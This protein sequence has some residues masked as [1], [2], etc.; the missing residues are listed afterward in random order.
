M[1]IFL[2]ALILALLAGA[3]FV[4]STDVGDD[5]GTCVTD[6]GYCGYHDTKDAYNTC[7]ICCDADPPEYRNC[8][9]S[10]LYSC[11][12]SLAALSGH[13]CTRSCQAPVHDCSYHG[14]GNCCPMNNGLFKDC[15]RNGYCKDRTQRNYCKSLNGYCCPTPG[16]IYLEC[17]KTQCSWHPDST[18]RRCATR[19][20]NNRGEVLACSCAK[21]CG[22]GSDTEC[23]TSRQHVYSAC[24]WDYHKNSTELGRLAE[25]I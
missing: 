6:Q 8:K 20:D 17:C 14:S 7:S 11:G 16:G 19:G 25:T 5:C 12:I 23:C 1:R 21:T 3:A 22:T 24:G 13:F 10:G 2:V 15:C 9:N 4:N 18:H